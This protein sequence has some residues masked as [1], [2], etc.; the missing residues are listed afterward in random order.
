MVLKTHGL[1]MQRENVFFFEKKHATFIM[2]TNAGHITGGIPISLLPS[3]VH[4]AE[5]VDSSSDQ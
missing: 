5:K 1:K 3:A 2:L 4:C